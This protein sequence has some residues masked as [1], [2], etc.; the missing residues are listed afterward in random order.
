MSKTKAYPDTTL[1]DRLRSDHPGIHA[2]L[3]WEMP[4]PKYTRVA[5]ISCYLVGGMTVHVVTYRSGGWDALTP[6]KST[7]V[8]A[9]VEDVVRRTIG[10]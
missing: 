7:T 4:G 10:E 9:V 8:D 1:I 5:W 6:C 2:C 3:A